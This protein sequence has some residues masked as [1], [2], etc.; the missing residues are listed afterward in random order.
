MPA[1]AVSRS[2]AGNAWPTEKHYMCHLVKRHQAL[3]C[4]RGRVVPS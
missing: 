3:K 4:L 2:V 1:F